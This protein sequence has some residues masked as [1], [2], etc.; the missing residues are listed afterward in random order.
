MLE[1]A[2]ID[3]FEVEPQKNEKVVVKNSLC[4]LRD[5]LCGLHG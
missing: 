3:M 5:V 2:T 4:D 1:A